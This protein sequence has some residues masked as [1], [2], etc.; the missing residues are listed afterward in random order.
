MRDVAQNALLQASVHGAMLGRVYATRQML[1]NVVTMLAGTGFAWFVDHYPVRWL[2]LG[3]TLIY[4]VAFL[5]AWL[6]LTLRQARLQAHTS[7]SSAD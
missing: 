4:G 1:L 3:G 7:L 5:Y 6:H 2:F